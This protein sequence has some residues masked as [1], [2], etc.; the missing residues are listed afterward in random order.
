MDAKCKCEYLIKSMKR[1]IFCLLLS[2]CFRNP[3]PEVALLD[4]FSCKENLEK[5]KLETNESFPLCPDKLD[6][7]KYHAQL[8][9]RYLNKFLSRR[10]FIKAFN[11]FD[12]TGVLKVKKLEES[13]SEIQNSKIKI[14]LLP[15]GIRLKHLSPEKK[16]ILNSLLKNKKIIVASGQIGN[17]INKDDLLWPQ[18]EA[19]R[20]NVTLVSYQRIKGVIPETILHKNLIEKYHLH[21]EGEDL[22]GSSQA[23]LNEYL[24][25]E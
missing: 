9:L 10:I 17:G 23:V 19:K 18:V 22:S 1:V 15:I 3:S 4:T 7:R 8:T 25:L 20:K 12:A 5:I 16:K 14:I 13:L 2:S 11:V 6:K 24:S 21:R